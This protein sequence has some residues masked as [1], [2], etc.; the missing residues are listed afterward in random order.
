MVAIGNPLHLSLDEAKS[1]LISLD[2]DIDLGMLYGNNTAAELSQDEVIAVYSILSE[3]IRNY[4]RKLKRNIDFNDYRFHI[5]PSLNESNEKVVFITA[6]CF[7]RG[8]EWENFTYYFGILDGGDCYFRTSF[9]VMLNGHGKMPVIIPN[10][11][12]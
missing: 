9:Q 4:N 8:D 10:G 5:E 3:A 2:Y 11:V 1:K 6:Y 12:A 7:D